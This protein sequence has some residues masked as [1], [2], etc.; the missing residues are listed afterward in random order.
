MTINTSPVT[1]QRHLK[2][3]RTVHF[4]Y[5][6]E[7]AATNY[8][9]DENQ[10]TNELFSCPKE[11][12]GG[13]HN[14]L[15]F[16][17]VLNIFLSITAFL[18]NTL[19]LVALHKETSL[20]LPSRLLFRSLATTDLCVGIIAEPLA[21]SYFISVI[22]EQWNICRYVTV[23]SYITGYI[24]CSASLFTLTAISVD[25][26]LALLLGFRF[27]QVVTLRRIYLAV[28]VFWLVS[29]AASAI[30]F[31]NYNITLWYGYVA[32]SLCLVT[33]GFSY[34]KI[35]LT[36]RHHHIQVQSHAQQGQPSQANRL[37]IA[38]YR[39]TVSTALWVQLTLVACYLP[40]AIVDAL[41]T[42]RGRSPS[43]H[44]ARHIT[45]T[46]VYFNS[47][48]NPILYYWKITEVRRAVKD[49]IRGLCCS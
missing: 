49:T 36:L 26:L 40:H 9:G 10:K 1:K 21:V 3:H 13:I 12:T 44:L 24:L 4:S 14:Q 31:W 30:S 11:S 28:T 32:I 19:I 25:R 38:R 34:V 33:S 48:L 45:S 46:L 22:N 37:N 5:C 47:S 18:G 20:H 7:M 2:I 29:I 23:A 16:L 39:K 6:N 35:F 8:T 27:R 41:T 15:I 17:S 42:Q 43:L